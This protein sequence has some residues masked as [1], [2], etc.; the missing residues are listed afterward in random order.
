[1][2]RPPHKPYRGTGPNAE[3]KNHVTLRTL[4]SELSVQQK[5]RIHFIDKELFDFAANHSSSDPALIP[6]ES[7]PLLPSRY[8]CLNASNRRKPTPQC[9]SMISV[10]SAHMPGYYTTY[11]THVWSHLLAHRAH[12]CRHRPGPSG[13]GTPPP[14]TDIIEGEVFP[15]VHL[16]L[17]LAECVGKWLVHSEQLVHTLDQGPRTNRA[18]YYTVTMR[19]VHPTEPA[20][21]VRQVIHIEQVVH[22]GFQ[23]KGAPVGV[24]WGVLDRSFEG[25][26]RNTG[27]AAVII[28]VLHESHNSH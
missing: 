2:M 20:D 9:K 19:S 10:L 6:Q 7:V 22:H 23:V 8:F 25:T 1:M 16:N 28:F 18:V 13:S 21:T 24:V 5:G 15:A 3:S 11:H 12:R 26:R 14:H 4:T 27:A 17:G